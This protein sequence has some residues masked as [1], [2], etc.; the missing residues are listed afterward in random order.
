MHTVLLYIE[1]VFLT[2]LS[3]LMFL[4]RSKPEM[5][6]I[7]MILASFLFRLF[8]LGS[9]N[10]L[11]EEAYYWNYSAHLDWSYLD[12]PPLVALLIKCSSMMF[13]TTEWAVRFPSLLCWIGMSFYAYRWTQLWGQNGLFSVFLL[14]FLPF[15]FLQS[16]VMT[17]DQPLLVAWAAVLYY[18]YRACVLNEAKSWF[19]AG[20]A[21][22]LGLLS[23]YTIVLL[24]PATFLFLLCSSR[25]FWLMRVEP[26][27]A[28]G[29]ALVI[30][31]PVIYWNSTHQW[32]SFAFQSSRRL[33]EAH[34]FSTHE[35]LGLLCL[36]LMPAGV[37][38]L[39][40]LCNFRSLNCTGADEKMQLLFF[41]CFFFVPV[42]VFFGFSLFH[43][44]KFN[45]IG[46]SILALI[47]WLSKEFSKTRRM[48]LA[49]AFSAMLVYSMMLGIILTG[50][51]GSLYQSLFGK[52]A[53][54]QNWSESLYKT[55]T[56]L[57]Q[58][59]QDLPILVALDKYNIA[60][61]FS[62]YQAKLHPN[63]QYIVR[64]S[65]LFGGE[66]LMYRY[67]SDFDVKNKTLLLVTDNILH[68]Q[69][70]AI[71][72]HTLEISPV[73]SWF[74]KSQGAGVAVKPYFYR[75]MKYL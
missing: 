3:E 37:L 29:L 41:R 7:M 16:W 38:G 53:D 55:L 19:F 15:F 51:P 42:L 11:V 60:S 45:W 50:Y 24:L 33:N 14:S 73:E 20:V 39:F 68:F 31:S 1:A 10:L 17:P 59:T 49:T 18:L 48:W 61:E 74:S 12:H 35:L 27:L 36:F 23:K 58:E 44:V 26:Y 65:D 69:N 30:F 9:M 43:E 56:D 62:F 5:C 22:G 25:R 28:L 67:W 13:G 47:P 70:P 4:S 8:Y 64:G 57:E 21:L 6:I 54:W 40:K 52:Y 2:F 72:L 46:P 63:K 34:H 66:S 71:P 32:V 75:M